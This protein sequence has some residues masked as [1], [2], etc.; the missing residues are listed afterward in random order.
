MNTT[1]M[2]AAH[3]KIIDACYAEQKLLT[4]EMRALINSLAGKRR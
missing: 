1:D 4:E 3:Q 2:L